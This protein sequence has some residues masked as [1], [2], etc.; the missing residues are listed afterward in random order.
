MS[1]IGDI[2]GRYRDALE[3][4]LEDYTSER[5]GALE[6]L[7]SLYGPVFQHLI[8]RYGWMHDRTSPEWERILDALRE[9]YQAP[10]EDVT[11]AAIDGTCGKEMLSE[12]V[13][14]YG[15]SFAQQGRLVLDRSKYRIEYRRWLPSEDTSYVAYL[16]VP[17]SRLEMDADNEWLYRTDDAERATASVAHTCLMQLAEVYLAYRRVQEDNP[18]RVILLD[19]SLSSMLLSNDVMHL[20]QPYRPDRQVLGW[21]GAHIDIWGRQF[22][23]AD[24]LVAHAHPM[25]RVLGIPS[26]RANALAERLV[27][28]ITDYWQIGETGERD[29]GGSIDLTT[30]ASR[31]WFG[32]NKN[33]LRERINRMPAPTDLSEKGYG[34]FRLTDD[35]VEPIDRL[36]NGQPRTLRQRWTELDRLFDRLCRD[37]FRERRL[38]ALQLRYAED[39]HRRGRHWMNTNDLKFLISLGLRLLMENCWRK[40][41][42]LLGIAKDSASRFLSRNFLS[43]MHQTDQI[44]VPTTAEPAGSDRLICEMIPIVDVSITQPWSTIEFDSI[45]MTLRA[46]LDE[47][48]QPFISGVR[49]DVLMPSDG[50]FHRSLVQM[51][52]SQRSEKK[53]PLMGHVLFLD[54]LADPLMDAT[55]R[56]KLVVTRDSA[57]RP[58]YSKSA[59]EDNLGQDVAMLVAYLLT[60]NCFPEAIGQPDPLHRADQGAKAL[61][62]RINDLIR[63]SVAR[64][65]NNPLAWSFRDTRIQSGR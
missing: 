55:R 40:R 17:L 3:H 52:L 18:P 7:R 54:R 13:V 59:D 30:L 12:M 56:K 57:V 22:E 21:I 24:A 27:A 15:A 19:H 38:E 5:R 53:S 47:H 1:E 6:A 28:E 31:G 2:Y 16:P 20:V 37:L 58:C 60:K 50:L 62:S 33:R 10:C 35:R 45:F 9:R 63:Q 4:S 29:A 49:G 14:F 23:L 26:A 25:N 65:R 39:P 61:G 51:F 44:Q 43:V 8:R 34:A 64:L 42:L 48:E 36:Q 46:I 32:G 11:F 41:I